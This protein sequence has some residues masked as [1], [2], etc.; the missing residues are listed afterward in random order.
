[1]KKVKFYAFLCCLV[2]I[3]LVLTPAITLV[4]KP[5]QTDPVQTTTEKAAI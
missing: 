5:Q 4:G 2:A 3:S 1:M